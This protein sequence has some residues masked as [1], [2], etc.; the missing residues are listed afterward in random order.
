MTN[1]ANFD[2]LV[3]NQVAADFW[4]WVH[5]DPYEKVSILMARTLQGGNFAAI[6]FDIKRYYVGTLHS[7][8]VSSR[9]GIDQKYAIPEKI[10]E[11]RGKMQENCGTQRP[12][13]QNH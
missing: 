6:N 13:I 12:L 7:T 5:V 3:E 8:R 1:L 10:Q 11:N 4:S 9:I 2:K